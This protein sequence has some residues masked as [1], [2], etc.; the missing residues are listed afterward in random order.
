MTILV[1]Y[2]VIDIRTDQG[3]F[4]ACQQLSSQGLEEIEIDVD[5]SRSGGQRHAS[6]PLSIRLFAFD[7][8]V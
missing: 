1:S 8:S 2:T 5:R 6:R 3:V 7:G 4:I